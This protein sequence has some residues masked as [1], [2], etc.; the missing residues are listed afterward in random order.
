[1]TASES[2]YRAQALPG[3]PIKNRFHEIE[4]ILSTGR[5]LAL[6]APTGSGK[7]TLLPVLMLTKGLAN[8][9]IL[10]TQPRRLAAKSVASRISS[11]LGSRL[12]ETAG[13][14]IRGEKL[15]SKETRIEVVTE[16][17]ALRMLQSDPF[18]SGY[19]WIIID[20]FHERHIETDLLLA[21]LRD[22]RRDLGAEEAPGMITMTATWQGQ[23][24]EELSEF[25]FHRIEGRLF[26]VSRDFSRL[27]SDGPLTA[28]LTEAAEKAWDET[29]GKILVFLP[30]RRE[31]EK[32]FETLR[33]SRP[34][35]ELS[36]LYGALDFKL[37]QEVINYTGPRR[38]IILST[39]IA[40]TSLTIEGVTA[41]ID[42]G[43]ERLPLFSP[44]GGLTRLVTR[45]VSRAS[46]QQRAGRAG[47]LGPGKCYCLW[48]ESEDRELIERWDPEILT[49]D[50]CEARLQAAAWGKSCLPWITEPPK[51]A[52]TRAE[53]LL[54]SL[55][56]ISRDGAL[57]E[58]GKLMAA[59]PMHPRLSHMVIE[60]PDRDMAS[61]AAAVLSEGHRFKDRGLGFT[62]RLQRVSEG[63]EFA[64]IRREAAEISKRVRKTGNSGSRTSDAAT[65][66]ALLSLAYPDRIAR[67]RSAGNYEL[68]TGATVTAAGEIQSEWVVF[69]ELGGTA[70]RLRAAVAEPLTFEELE[71]FHPALFEKSRRVEWNRDTGRFRAAE[72]ELFG[73]CLLK[74]NQSRS[75]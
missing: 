32:A 20:E 64:G 51:G 18:M 35:A 3:Y 40:E 21:F 28:R 8:G 30:G 68:I 29:D 15:V 22:L 75:S 72:S 2:A 73:R 69:P 42:S 52:W 43:L 36:R 60:A 67:R 50:L 57:S 33:Q 63:K 65:A 14:R 38:Q 13:Y 49:G 44:A 7:T 23:P 16:G 37:Q 62:D 19:D 17:Y 66:G 54:H 12:G 46:A 4:K 27:A 10:L 11:L 61:L 70:D 39:S 45:Q 53:E 26:P 55:G 56:A 74:K 24:A 6:E 9:K 34:E 5:P 71:I 41:V 47:R 31:I 59:L 1:M 25:E 48:T 58:R